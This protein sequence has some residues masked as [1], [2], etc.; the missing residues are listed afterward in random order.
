MKSYV[1]K[2]FFGFLA[3]ALARECTESCIIDDI[4]FEKGDK[5]LIPSYSIHRDDKIWKNATSFT[6]ERFGRYAVLLHYV[7]YRIM[8]FSYSFVRKKALKIHFDMRE[9]KM[10]QGKYYSTLHNWNN[11]KNIKNTHGRVIL[12]VKM[13]A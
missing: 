5:I 6:P 11:L 7:K 12:L 10:L 13:Q 3:F 2:V 8:S 9:H 4:V 1:Q